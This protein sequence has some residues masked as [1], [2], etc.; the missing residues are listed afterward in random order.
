MAR[1]FPLFRVAAL[2][3]AAVAL[4]TALPGF[5]PAVERS[6]AIDAVLAMNRLDVETFMMLYDETDRSQRERVRRQLTV[7]TASMQQLLPT[8]PDTGAM[9]G[10]GEAWRLVNSSIVG[11]R[12]NRGMIETGYD[13]RTLA[14]LRTAMPAL[15]R[16]LRDRYRL[17]R[18]ASTTEEAVLHAS[19]MV[20]VY[21][22]TAASPLGGFSDNNDESIDQDLATMV[23]HMDRLLATLQQQY[24]GDPERRATLARVQ[25]KWN[26]I[27]GTMLRHSQ[28]ATPVIVYR[29]GLDI[30]E[31]LRRLPLAG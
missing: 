18:P 26:F 15:L 17:D 12:Q 3:A 10:N 24:A 31:Q 27:R 4:L 19:D 7:A 20:A 11:D 1:A 30:V 6:A 28:Q 23:R 21:I 16:A 9:V 2:R 8:L 13:A 14:E 29:H 22:R 5:V 25:T